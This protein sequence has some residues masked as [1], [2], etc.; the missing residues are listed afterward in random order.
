MSTEWFGQLAV[1][2]D[3][4]YA[5]NMMFL[6]TIPWGWW[7]WFRCWQMRA[8]HQR[9]RTLFIVQSI[10]IPL[11]STFTFMIVFHIP[12]PKPLGLFCWSVIDML[13]MSTDMMMSAA[14]KRVA[15][16]VPVLEEENA[17]L[18]ARIRQLEAAQEEKAAKTENHQNEGSIAHG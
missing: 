12:Y 14:L 7:V 9:I 6:F 3:L 17:R 11:Y 1:N 18:E 16:K 2:P 5:T 10:A 13:F 8:H 15:K 4:I